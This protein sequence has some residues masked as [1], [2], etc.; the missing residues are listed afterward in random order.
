MFHTYEIYLSHIIEEVEGKSKGPNA[1]GEGALL[2]KIKSI[3]KGFP[4]TLIAREV[5]CVRNSN[6]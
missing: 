2:N 5:R 6:C 3:A 1:L 4:Q